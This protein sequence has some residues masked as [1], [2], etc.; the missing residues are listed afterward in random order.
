MVKRPS[1]TNDERGERM[2]TVGADAGALLWER[3]VRA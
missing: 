3:A 1:M 2:T